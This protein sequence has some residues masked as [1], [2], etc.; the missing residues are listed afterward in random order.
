M[1]VDLVGHVG[2]AVFGFADGTIL[3]LGYNADLGD[4]GHVIVV[5][6]TIH[7]SLS[8]NETKLLYVLYGHL[9]QASLRGKRVGDPVRAGKVLGWMGHALESGG[10]TQPHVHVQFALHAPPTHD[11]PGAVCRSQRS[12]A[13]QE[14]LD[15]RY[16]IGDLY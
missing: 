10:W 9:D 6:H 11:M 1:G 15:P 8:R 5:N 4:Y 14:Y 7:T 3:S 13:L 16:I 2:T 12:A